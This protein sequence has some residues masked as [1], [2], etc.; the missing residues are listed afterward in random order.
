MRV[1]DFEMMLAKRRRR[2]GTDDFR[3]RGRLKWAGNAT[4]QR[5]SDEAFKFRL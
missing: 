1:G 4:S 3:S 2:G 5:K